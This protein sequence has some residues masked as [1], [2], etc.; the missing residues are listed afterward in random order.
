MHCSALNLTQIKKQAKK[1]KEAVNISS[2]H[3]KY[4]QRIWT[5]TFVYPQLP[6]CFTLLEH[7]HLCSGSALAR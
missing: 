5:L 7:T 2:T 3:S 1:A 6:E 4:Q